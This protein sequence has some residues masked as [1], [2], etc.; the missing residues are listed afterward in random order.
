MTGTEVLMKILFTLFISPKTSI[1]EQIEQ[2]KIRIDIFVLF[3]VP[4]FYKTGV[5]KND[6]RNWKMCRRGA[7]AVYSD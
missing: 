2:N 7:N 5:D 1:W 3:A 4:C 6:M